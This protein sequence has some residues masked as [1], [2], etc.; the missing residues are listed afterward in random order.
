MSN[1]YTLHNN[2][3][4]QQ[5][6]FHI[7]GHIAKIEYLIK[8]EKNKIYLIHTEVP[9]ALSGRGIGSALVRQVLADIETQGWQLVPRC[10]FVASYIKRHPEW[11]RLVE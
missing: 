11:Q 1:T 2:T 10:P 6:E 3:D 4:D 5:Y 7:D 8:E 9:E